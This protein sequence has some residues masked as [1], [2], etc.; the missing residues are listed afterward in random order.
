VTAEPDAANLPDL[1]SASGVHETL[2][3]EVVELDPTRVVL[4]MP[5]GPPVHQPFGILHGGVSALLAESAASVGGSLNVP[6]GKGIVGIEISASHLRGAVSGTLIAVGT[7]IRIGRTIQV[8][9]IELTDQDG[10]AICDAKCTLAVVD[11]PS[12]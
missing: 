7:P 12:S 10:R 1:S 2:G 3:I 5:I 9:R 4:T 11:R 6:E 8:W